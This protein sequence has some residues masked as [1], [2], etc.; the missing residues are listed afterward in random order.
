VQPRRP[1]PA[2]Q[3]PCAP[4]VQGA[5]GESRSAQDGA[6]IGLG[7]SIF[8]I[9]ERN[10]ITH[11]LENIQQRLA[12]GSQQPTANF[13]TTSR[14]GQLIRVQMAPVLGAVRE[15]GGEG[16]RAIAG[17]VLMLDNI[18]RNFEMDSRRD[19]CCNR[20]PRAAAPRSA[21]SAPPSRTCSTI[22]T[23]RRS[24]AT[25]SSASS[26][27]RW[28]RWASASTGRSTS[29]PMP[30]R[31]AGR[32]RTCSARIFIAAAQRR[33]E[34]KLG[35]PTKLDEVAEGVWVKVDSFSLLQGVTYLAS[36][37]HDEYDIR[38]LRFRLA[39]AGRLVRLDLVWS[40]AVVGSQTL[41]AW[42]IDPMNVAGENSPLTLREV[43]E[44]HGGEI[45]FEREKASH[46]AFIRMLM[47][48]FRPAAGRRRSSRRH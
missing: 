2:L 8:A 38:E 48:A 37:L 6:L 18:T 4:A 23:W 22:R 1:H 5:G 11:A 26:A 42:E 31:R 14:A 9:L 46:R 15:A 3:Q 7:R 47:P 30:S 29:S 27:T 20:S 44:R 16:E 32:S 25:A 17:Y 33:I 10:L 36:R 12:R 34:T 35:L 24:S 28:R 43:I 19:A 13:V 40:G 41:L 45:W 39:P 21:T